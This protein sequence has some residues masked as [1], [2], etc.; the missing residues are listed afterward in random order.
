MVTLFLSL[1]LCHS[2]KIQFVVDDKNY[3]T[4]YYTQESPA[5]AAVELGGMLTVALAGVPS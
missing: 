2:M 4:A 3:I 5:E 1:F